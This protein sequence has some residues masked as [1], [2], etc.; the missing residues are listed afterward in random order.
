M[1][2]MAHEEAS[3]CIACELE[4]FYKRNMADYFKHST[5]M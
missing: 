1:F 4:V 5:V 2:S 3:F